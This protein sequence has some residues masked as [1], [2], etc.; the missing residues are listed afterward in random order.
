MFINAQ[1]ARLWLPHV[2]PIA[3]DP[4]RAPEH[5]TASVNLAR[6]AIEAACVHSMQLAQRSLGLSAFLVGNP[7]ERICRDLA[8]YL[9]QPAPDEALR[10]AARHF[11]AN[12]PGYGLP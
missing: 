12:A 5:A 7:V 11:A 10:G 9:R 3:E 6:I 8:T 4:G 2:A 1:T